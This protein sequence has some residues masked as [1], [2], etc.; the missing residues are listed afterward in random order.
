MTN[1]P[2]KIRIGVSDSE[3][4]LRHAL[5]L[6]H[7]LSLYQVE[8]EIKYISHVNDI[9]KAH[10]ASEFG[11]VMNPLTSALLNDDI[12]VVIYPLHETS[13]VQTEALKLCALSERADTSSQLLIRHDA[14]SPASDLRLKEKAVIGTQTSLEALQLKSLCPSALTCIVGQNTSH[15][16]NMLQDGAIDALLISQVE[17]HDSDQLLPDLHMVSLHPK[18]LIPKPGQGVHCYQTHI[19]NLRTR[20][21]MKLVHNP[22]VAEET[23]IERKVLRLLGE[24]KSTSLGVYCKKD[25][26]GNFHAVAVLA[27]FPSE[28]IKKV[29][30]SQSTSYQLAENIY[31][32]LTN[33][34]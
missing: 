1:P 26:N 8:G 15:N 19:E 16:L 6:K 31:Q 17:L 13:I 28:E 33:E 7:K 21:I 12:D 30:L 34:L 22:D 27:N 9:G 5:E 4:D 29:S 20:K 11:M 25:N 24:I 14:F 3:P 32:L 18:E 10:I 2:L 23:N